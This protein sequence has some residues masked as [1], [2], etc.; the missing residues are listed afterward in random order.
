MRPKQAF[1]GAEAAK[2]AQAYLLRKCRAADAEYLQ[3][4]AK[5]DLAFADAIARFDFADPLT[6]DID[7]RH[8]TTLLLDHLTDDQWRQLRTAIRVK[9]KKASTKLV[10]IDITEEAHLAL[11]RI[12]EVVCPGKSL[13][14]AILEMGRRVNPLGE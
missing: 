5:T 9:R 14:H 6:V 13:S 4:G 2:I 11:K 8:F 1:R 12:A 10:S 7:L 3:R